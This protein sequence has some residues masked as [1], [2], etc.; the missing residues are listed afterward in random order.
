MA[1]KVIT[2]PDAPKL[3]FS[4]AI[5]AGDYIFVSGQVG[6][7]DAKGNEVKGIEAQVRLCLENMKRVLVAAGAS[8]DDV[9]KV[10]VFLRN[11]EDFAKMNE[12]YQGYFP[13]DKPAR[14]TV[15][16]GLA[17]PTM[18]VEMECIAYCQS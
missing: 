1:K 18:L 11:E 12:V 15:I 14:S 5:R 9:V 13:E 17:L 2:I 16:A 10:T 7:V 3:P 4:P 8:L 6:F